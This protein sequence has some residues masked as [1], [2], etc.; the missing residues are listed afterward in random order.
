M[1][2][3]PRFLFISGRLC[4]D[5][6]HTGGEGWRARW[7]RWNAP[8]DLA[9]WMLAC[10]GLAVRAQV[11]ADDV[12]SARALREA[13]W[14][15]AQAMLRGRGLPA[16]VT[17]TLERAAA[18]PDLV[19]ALR[20]G[21]KVWAPGARGAHVLATV[22]RDAIDLFGTDARARLRECK[23]PRCSLLFVDLSRP[24]KRAWCTMR[25]CGNLNKLARYRA[26]RRR[27][28]ENDDSA[29]DDA[30]TTTT[31]TKTSTA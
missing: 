27:T 31:P 7:E 25:R 11:E 24:G 15:G 28:D 8:S 5:F 30:T 26:G 6:V 2:W 1:P 29:S 19:P 9:D 21:K 10:P 14:A 16:A 22:A 4:L 3:P 12:R 20:A 13:I 18:Q 17:R 23:N